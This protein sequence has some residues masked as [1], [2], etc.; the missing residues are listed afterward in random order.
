M[1]A[2]R[3]GLIMRTYKVEIKRLISKK[4]GEKVKYNIPLFVE[5]IKLLHFC[6]INIIREK[7]R[8]MRLILVIRF[9]FR[10]LDAVTQSYY[11]NSKLEFKLILLFIFI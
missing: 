7:R 3:G 4:K 9:F 1:P 6:C 10:F 5:M 2:S 8:I 11:N